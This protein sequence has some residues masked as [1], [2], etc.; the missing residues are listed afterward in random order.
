MFLDL[1]FCDCVGGAVLHSVCVCVCV[2]SAEDDQGFTKISCL[3]F[4]FL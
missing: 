1:S 3:G 4:S 2:C